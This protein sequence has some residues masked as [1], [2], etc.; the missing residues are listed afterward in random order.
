[1]FQQITFESLCTVMK[2]DVLKKDNR[3][4]CIRIFYDAAKIVH[5]RQERLGKPRLKM[6]QIAS[7]L[8][9]V[10][11][12]HSSAFR[13][14]AEGLLACNFKDCPED[15]AI[16][17]FE[18]SVLGTVADIYGTKIKIDDGGLA[19]LYKDRYTGKHQIAPE[20]YEPMRGKRLPW[21]PHVLGKTPWIYRID[22]DV[23][24]KFQRSYLYTALVTIP[25]AARPID[26]Y[27]IVVVREENGAR[28]YLTAF[29]VGSHN[30]FLKRI[31]EGTPFTG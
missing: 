26:R 15:K 3:D 30:A 10:D 21:V 2:A 1:M 17:Y 28:R 8:L 19:S 23:R 11:F 16:D 9:L 20:N 4:R 6:N 27:F 12:Y 18:K 25:L 22:E 31:E 7:A 5:Y 13:F 24:G 29:E 14:V